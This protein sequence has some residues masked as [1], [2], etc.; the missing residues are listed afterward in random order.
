[1]DD[2]HADANWWLKRR[3]TTK[4]KKKE[5]IDYDVRAFFKRFVSARSNGMEYKL[6]YGRNCFW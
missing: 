5:N 2:Q 4:K 6:E 3:Q 1:M